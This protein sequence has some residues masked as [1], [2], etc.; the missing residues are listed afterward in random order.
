MIAPEV[1]LRIGEDY[2]DYGE[3][4][5]AAQ[6]YQKAMA[7]PDSRFYDKALYKLAW[8][9]FQI[10]DYDKAIKTF[11]D[12]IAWYETHKEGGSTASALREEAI[13]YLA[14]SLAEDDWDNDGQDD[15][16]RGIDRALSYLQGGTSWERDI[17]AQYAE[18]LYDL[19]DVRKYS[20]SILVYKRLIEMDPTALKAVQF[21]Q[22]VIQI[23]DVLRDVDGAT[24]ERQA[25]ADMFS[26]DSP[27][28]Q[29]N[30]EEAQRIANSSDTVEAEMRRRA[31]TLHQ[32]AQELKT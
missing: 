12:L 18:A 3:F 15:P 13:D 6:A 5:K 9:Y 32:R 7:Y 27:W 2:F 17:I 23:Y 22:K 31:L 28:A 8:T 26:S 25:L 29:A 1:F 21:Q 19:H 30:R 16:K 11:K 24:R 20:E 10:Y 14:K 4:E